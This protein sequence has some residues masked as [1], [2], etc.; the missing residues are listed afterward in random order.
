MAKVGDDLW[1]HAG[2]LVHPESVNQH[3]KQINGK[4]Y[5]PGPNHHRRG[6]QADHRVSSWRVENGRANWR[7]RCQQHPDRQCP[8][9]VGMRTKK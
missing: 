9:M 2:D 3:I 4:L 7:H 6:Q 1:D 5:R 8:R